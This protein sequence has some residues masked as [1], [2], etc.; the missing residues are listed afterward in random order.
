MQEVAS[1]F[2]KAAS[3]LS[4][5]HVH[6]QRRSFDRFRFLLV[7]LAKSLRWKVNVHVERPDNP[8]E[9]AAARV[10]LQLRTAINRWARRSITVG[11][12]LQVNHPSQFP[13]K[14]F[15]NEALIKLFGGQV[16]MGIM[17]LLHRSC[18]HPEGKRHYSGV[19]SQ[20]LRATE[21]KGLLV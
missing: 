2:S 19:D 16:N 1:C 4:P 15:K 20:H 5:P 14:G 13:L 10:S 9:S 3:D 8:P 6:T 7:P 18:W 17:D 12:G 11:T 21:M